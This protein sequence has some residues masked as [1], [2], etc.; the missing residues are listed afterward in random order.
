MKKIL[1]GTV[2]ASN[3]DIERVKRSDHP[4]EKPLLFEGAV[5]SSVYERYNGYTVKSVSINP[6][7]TSA[8]V[9]VDFEYTRYPPKITWT[10]HVQLI[11]SGQGWKIDNISFDSV[12]NTK[13]LKASL[14]DFIQSIN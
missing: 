7:G 8:D 4:D 13:N 11:N 6:S 2:S 10:D 12:G 9:E 14:K 3:A 5:F 1:E